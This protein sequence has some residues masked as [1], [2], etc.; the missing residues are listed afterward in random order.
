MTDITSGILNY[1]IMCLEQTFGLQSHSQTISII[2]H[3][4]IPPQ[5]APLKFAVS[6][7]HR[8]PLPLSNAQ[9]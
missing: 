5:H 4:H 7:T 3:A 9:K 1:A 8:N 6:S 2:L